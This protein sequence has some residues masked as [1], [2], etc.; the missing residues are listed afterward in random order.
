MERIT[1]ET[2]IP[3]LFGPGK[4][5]FTDGDPGIT[6]PTELN[7]DWFNTVQEEVS[8]AV[9]DA[10]LSLHPTERNQLSQAIGIRIAQ[11]LDGHNQDADPHD[12]YILKQ[13]KG[14]AGGVATLDVDGL[15][16]LAQLPPAIATDEELAASL[17]AHVD[18]LT[19]PHP[20]Y[21]TEAELQAVLL[22]GKARRHYFANH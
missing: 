2:A 7:A 17:A 13:Q 6:P 16:P 12:Q 15:V 21:I 5:G 19:D 9:E 20:Q 4:P 14:V 18:P 11:V 22:E 8:N 3:D 10:G 1:S